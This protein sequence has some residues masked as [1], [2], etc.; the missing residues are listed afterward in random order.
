M[1]SQVEFEENL[2]QVRRE[3]TQA[4]RNSGRLE[5]SVR[6]LPVTKNWPSEVVAYCKRAGIFSVGENRVQEALEKQKLI[7]GV[8]WELIGHLQ[9]NKV[10]KVV[11]AFDRIQTVDS[12]KLLNRLNEASIRKDESQRILLQVNAG[13]DPAKYGCSL[14]AAPFLLEKALAQGNLS[15][16]GLM[17]IAP[18]SPD[19]PDV[20]KAA[21]F[22]LRNLR[23]RLSA[24]FAVDL[25]ELSMGMTLDMAQAIE[26]GSTMVRVGS[27][28]FG[29]RR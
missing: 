24:Q 2:L 6:L 10:G 28:L 17:T 15:V 1:I 13:K 3:I 12:E 5:S 22:E 7:Q 14:D 23:D 11:G 9:G 21:F 27:A 20:A 4:C 18:Y 26:A 29:K 19:N 25:P 16:E 8:S